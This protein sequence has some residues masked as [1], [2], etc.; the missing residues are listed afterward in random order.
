[1]AGAG[2][3]AGDRQAC[4]ALLDQPVDQSVGLT[5]RAK[6][7]K[8]DDGTVLDTGHEVGH[9]LDDLVDHARRFLE[10]VCLA[11]VAPRRGC[12]KAAQFAASLDMGIAGLLGFR[13]GA[14]DRIRRDSLDHGSWITH[15]CFERS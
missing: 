10:R 9:G 8:K 2:V 6:A 5:D 13:S 7:A 4:G 1:M 3:V 11:G 14:S 12:A 15:R